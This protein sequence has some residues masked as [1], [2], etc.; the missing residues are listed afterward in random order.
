MEPWLGRYRFATSES[1]VWESREAYAAVFC[2][3]V[4]AFEYLLK[5]HL[6]S[7]GVQVLWIE[8]IQP[9]ADWQDQHGNDERAAALAASVSSLNR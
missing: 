1:E 7:L 6:L 3:S 5:S 8:D 9:L 4:E 2:D